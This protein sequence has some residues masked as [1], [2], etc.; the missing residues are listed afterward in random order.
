MKTNQVKAKLAAGETIY[1]CFTR[2]N[3]PVLIEIVSRLGFDF[4]TF[5]GEHS[6]IE[7]RDCENLTRAAE[8]FD[9]TP[10]VRVPTNQQ[11]IILR[12]MDTGVSGLVVPW[13]NTPEEAEN[14]V[15]SVKY[16]PRG[17]RGLAGTRAAEF[18]LRDSLGDYT[19][20]ANAET[21][22]IVQCESLTAVENAGAI[23]AIDGV[24]V[25]FVGP[26]DLSQSMGLPGQTTHP[27]VIATIQRVV[28][29]VTPTGKAVGIMTRTVD[30][31]H[32]WRERGIR[33]ITVGLENVI[34]AGVRSY[35]EAMKRPA[36]G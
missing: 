6:P 23:A 16:F 15:Q 19:V 1:G 30:N 4:I 13:V 32:F 35:I 20:R 11:P 21:L 2:F 26:T 7:P 27:D 34:I 18:G 31:A 9:V 36:A 10:L 28:D 25:V 29:A 3:D 33:F 22:V 24:D 5:D 12:Y 17:R 8:L 14:V